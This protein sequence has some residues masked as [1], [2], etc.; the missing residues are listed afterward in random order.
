M[1]AL[2]QGERSA[3]TSLAAATEDGLQ[4]LPAESG[5]S[6]VLLQ[7]RNAATRLLNVTGPVEPPPR[8]GP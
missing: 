6:P 4:Q 7:I 8:K 2:M 3:L 5:Y 1:A